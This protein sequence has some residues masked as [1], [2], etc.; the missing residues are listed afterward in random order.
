M[1]GGDR[2]DLILMHHGEQLA[3]MLLAEREH[4]DRRLMKAGHLPFRQTA[5]CPSHTVWTPWSSCYG[6][7]KTQG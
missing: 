6:R 3:G 1:A 7:F 4:Q 2:L 5:R